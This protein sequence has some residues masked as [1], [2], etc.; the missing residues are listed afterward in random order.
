MSV[1]DTL[2]ERGKAHGPFVDQA[3]M[4]QRLKIAMRGPAW[5]YLPS[6]KRE[7]LDMI[8]H[9][10]SRVVVGDHNHKDHWHDIQGYAK[11]AEDSCND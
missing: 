10:I 2:K 3:A 4:A 8:V 7:A 1:E 5:D 6:L 11:L 9:K